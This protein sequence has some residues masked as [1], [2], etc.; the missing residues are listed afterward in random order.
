[1][2]DKGRSLT[3][4]QGP[5]GERAGRGVPL[6]NHFGV[7]DETEDI[8]SPAGLSQEEAQ[9]YW[10]IG[11]E[12]VLESLESGRGI[13]RVKLKEISRGDGGGLESFNVSPTTRSDRRG[14]R[15]SRLRIQAT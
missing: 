9:M 6:A 1:M 8:A 2:R 11:A 4:G 3:H 15:L 5:G 13:D 12:G 14:L 10:R 7:L